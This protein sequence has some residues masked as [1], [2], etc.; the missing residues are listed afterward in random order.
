MTI[1][2]HIRKEIKEGATQFVNEDI[3]IWDIVAKE[4][5]VP[6]K[7]KNWSYDDFISGAEFGYTLS[8][9]EIEGKEKQIDLLEER[10]IL[11]DNRVKQLLEETDRLKSLIDQAWEQSKIKIIGNI[12]S[13]PL[14]P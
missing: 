2:E 1:P 10:E 14:T 13:N 12:Y 9:K 8:V 3:G 4:E 7:I 6:Q 5:I 11:W